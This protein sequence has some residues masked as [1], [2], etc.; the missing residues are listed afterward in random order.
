MEWTSRR[1]G[2]RGGSGTEENQTHKALWKFKFMYAWKKCSLPGSGC[3]SAWLSRYGNGDLL[4][5]SSQGW[6]LQLAFGAVL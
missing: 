3:K 5:Y 2:G 6:G 4:I 1:G